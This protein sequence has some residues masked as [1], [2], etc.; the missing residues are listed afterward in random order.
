[1]CSTYGGSTPGYTVYTVGAGTAYPN[2]SNLPSSSL[3]TVKLLVVGDFTVN[4]NFALLNSLVK[5]NPGFKISVDINWSTPYSLYLNNTKIFA[6]PPVSGIGTQ[7]WKGIEL[8]SFTGITVTNNSI[9]EDA[10][11]AIK[12]INTSFVGL[13]IDNSTFNRNRIGI[14]LEDSGSGG[15]FVVPPM[16]QYFVNNNFTCTSSLNGTT[17]EKTEIGLRIKSIECVTKTGE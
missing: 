4:N 12:A 11:N 7:L 6:C 16:L 1:M 3:S 13:A 8:N 9:I 10:E 17:N 14:N 5:V 2:S 15:W